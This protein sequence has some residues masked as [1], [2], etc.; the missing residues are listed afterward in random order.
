MKKIK[1]IFF[2]FFCSICSAQKIALIQ[3]FKKELVKSVP[4][5]FS[6]SG[7]KCKSF[8]VTT[9]NGK[10]EQI[11]DE[12]KFL[13]YPERKGFAKIMVHDNSRKEVFSDIYEV[14]DLTFSIK[15]NNGEKSISDIDRFLK[16][17]RLE[18]NSSDLNCLN[19]EWYCQ[20]DLIYIDTFKRVELAMDSKNGNLQLLQEKLPQ[21]KSND[22][23]VFRNF[24]IFV[25]A[26]EFVA[27]DVILEVM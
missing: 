19:F 11:K 4:F 13:I 1:L 14:K 22:I 21:L 6:L 17:S 25:G 26:E 15:I 10:I 3:E 24:R 9:D 20:F 7:N 8:I 5:P 23:L 2:V 16:T 18:L 12:C 27:S